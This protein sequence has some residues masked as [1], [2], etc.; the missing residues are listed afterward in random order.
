MV[1]VL[2]MFVSVV[3]VCLLCSSMFDMI[4]LLLVLMILAILLHCIS[5][6]LNQCPNIN[7]ILCFIGPTLLHDFNQPRFS[8]TMVDPTFIDIWPFAFRNATLQIGFVAFFIKDK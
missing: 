5:Q 2:T 4:V 7:T 1:A 8:K 3:V 6:E